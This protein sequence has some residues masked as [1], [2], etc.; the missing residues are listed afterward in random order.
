M[1]TYSTSHHTISIVE[2][3]QAFATLEREWNDL[4]HDS[5]LVTPFQSWA[6][7]YSW[8]QS[9]GKRYELQLIIVR[10]VEGLLI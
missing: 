10:N 6:W 4:Y 9:Y 2:D 7:L 3:A 1:T 5:L 8:W